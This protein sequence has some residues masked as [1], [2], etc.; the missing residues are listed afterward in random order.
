MVTLDEM[1]EL[2]VHGRARGVD[3]GMAGDTT[4][5]SLGAAD[6]ML[7][8][9]RGMIVM[10]YAR[11]LEVATLLGSVVMLQLRSHERPSTQTAR[12]ARR[13]L[14]SVRDR[15]VQLGHDPTV[16]VVDGPAWELRLIPGR[17]LLA[18][19]LGIT[20]TVAA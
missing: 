20:V 18:D 13:T 4:P 15:L 17:S 1:V 11:E 10:R 5:Q 8:P 7:K 6:P 9:P 12:L 16:H 2:L 3:L 14:R 19:E